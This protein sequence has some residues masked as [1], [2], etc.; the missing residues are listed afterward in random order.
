MSLK[1]DNALSNF[2][3][4]DE[5]ELKC[6]TFDIVIRQAALHNEK[7]RAAIAK[8]ALKAK[9]KSL[10][11]EQG[12]LTGNFEQDV[13]LFVDV[14]IV[15]WGKRPLKD[16]NKKVVPCNRENLTELFTGS[17]QGKV[18]FSRIQVAAV[19]D[20]LFLVTEEDLGK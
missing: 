4:A 13:A 20:E 11:V 17:K 10:V 15:G 5:I 19:D 1:L 9:K 16:D 18:L 2:D 3:T 6:G 8:R 7:F 14:L 12:T